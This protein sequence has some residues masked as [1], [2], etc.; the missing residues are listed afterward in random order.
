MADVPDDLALFWLC[1][2]YTSGVRFK[3]VM[4]G[5]YGMKI[6]QLIGRD[7][8][9]WWRSWWGVE[10]KTRGPH[11]GCEMVGFRNRNLV[12]ILTIL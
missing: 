6:H 1:V 2:F 9:G 10:V 5:A 4:E 12:N 3:G 11:T 8:Q 7:S